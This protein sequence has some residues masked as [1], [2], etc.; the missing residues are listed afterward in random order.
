MGGILGV[1]LTTLITSAPAAATTIVGERERRTWN[2]L[3]LSKLTPAQIL[4]GKAAHTLKLMLPSQLA[5]L[6]V[7]LA[8]VARGILS[9]LML[10]LIL[11][12]TLSHS[13]LAILLGLRLSLWSTNLR[14]ALRK[15]SG[16]GTGLTVIAFLAATAGSAALFGLGSPWLLLVP[17][18][19]AILALST[20]RHLWRRLLNE[21]Y[22]APKDFTG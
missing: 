2:A 3:L 5:V 4:G 12:I 22:Q 15:A 6:A 21:I 20:A 11:L 16:L 9:P 14:V 7:G 1:F 19:Y 18:A 13:V 10:P 8:A 17:L